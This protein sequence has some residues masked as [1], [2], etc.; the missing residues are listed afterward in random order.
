[1]EGPE[2][3]HWFKSIILFIYLFLFTI[4]GL[5]KNHYTD[6]TDRETKTRNFP[7]VP[8]QQEVGAC[9]QGKHVEMAERSI[10]LKQREGQV[11]I[12]SRLWIIG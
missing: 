3:A 7:K 4:T 10:S 5:T 6:L 8:Q 12:G 1:M 9:L 2:D 11:I